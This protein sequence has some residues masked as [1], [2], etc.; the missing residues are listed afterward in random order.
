MK[1]GRII[2]ILLVALSMAMHVEAQNK[3]TDGYLTDG[4]TVS[5]RITYNNTTYYLIPTSAENGANSTTV[6]SEECLWILN[7][8]KNDNSV[9][10]SFQPINN[11][12]QYLHV[13]GS[14][15]EKLIVADNA[16]AFTLYSD[17]AG[18][19]GKYVSGIFRYGQRYV[20][21]DS[22]KFRTR[23]NKNS[24]NEV[25]LEKWSRKDIAGGL[26]GEFLSSYETFG[27]AQTDTRES[28]TVQFKITREV[29]QSY[30]YCLNRPDVKIDI[31]PSGNVDSSSKIDLQLLNFGWLSNSGRTTSRTTC[32]NY[33][34]DVVKDRDLLSVSFTKHAPLV[35]TWDV[36]VTAVGSSP[37]NLKDINDNWID[38]SDELVAS[39]RDADDPIQTTHKASTIVKR[40]AYHRKEW[41][42]FPVNASLCAIS[43]S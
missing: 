6:L 25:T 30:Y 12:S 8:E 5:F 17:K 19:E 31:T 9:T 1:K 29:A 22:G 43:F 21:Y 15:R 27:L 20:G 23:S 28:K 14:W 24:A 40:E 39:F 38:Y 13:Y 16:P 35:N 37:M 26:K 2:R 11:T 42:V 36:T 34:D 7:I 41:P 32:S 3:V 10:Y 4:D 33:E 18:S